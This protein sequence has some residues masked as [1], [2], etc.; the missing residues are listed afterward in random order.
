MS[1]VYALKSG[2]S[3]RMVNSPFEDATQGEA[4]AVHVRYDD[5]PSYG[6]NNKRVA[7]ATTGRFTITYPGGRTSVHEHGPHANT[8]RAAQRGANPNAKTLTAARVEDE[9]HSHF[10]TQRMGFNDRR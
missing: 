1:G 2:Q 10:T 8:E 3:L 5:E 6:D 9:V 7:G 4:H